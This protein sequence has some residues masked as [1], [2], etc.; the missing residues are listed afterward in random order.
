MTTHFTKNEKCAVCGKVRKY[1]MIGSTNSFGYPDLDLRPA[2]MQRHTMFE[3]VHE[4]PVCG[5]V[6]E[7]VEDETTVDRTFLESTEYRSC[8]G[9]AIASELGRMFYRQSMIALKEG[10]RERAMYALLHCAWDSDDEHDTKTAAFCRTKA[11]S[12]MPE[13][14]EKDPEYA[15]TFRLIHADLLRRSGLFETLFELYGNTKFEDELMG[16]IMEFQKERALEKDTGCY[17]VDAV[18]ETE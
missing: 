18:N 6:S 17:R 16:K 10:D 14:I 12:L 1:T 9:N 13:L 5:Y 3:W 4:C 11:A 15:D 8:E 2:P 7:S